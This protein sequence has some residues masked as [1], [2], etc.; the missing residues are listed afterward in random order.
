[1]SKHIIICSDGTW[2]SPDQTDEGVISPTNVFKLA[3]AVAPE[4]AD[5]RRQLRYY[6][7]GVGTH[8]YDRIRG[9]LSGWGISR[10]I[11]EGYRFL[12]ANYEEGDEIFLFGFS[13]GAYTV[14]SLAGLLRNSGLL[15]TRNRY[16]LDDAYRLYRRRDPESHP[17]SMESE[18]FRRTYSRE[19]RVHFIGVW[20][21]V[22]ALGIPSTNFDIFNKILNIEFHDVDLSSRI[23]NAFQ[24]LAIDERRRAFEPSIWRKQDGVCCQRLEQ[25]WFSGVHSNVG[26]GYRDTGLSDIALRWMMDRAGECGLEFDLAAL[27]RLGFKIRPRWD[28][29]LVNSKKGLYQLM[30][31]Y[32]RPIE[33]TPDTNTAVA[34][35][36]WQRFESDPAYRKSCKGL[37]ILRPR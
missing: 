29:R 28:G 26:G 30:P 15:H 19:V 14:R 16:M 23:N 31:D 1:M 34:P 20:D 9:G 3:L 25:V 27:K 5:G 4:A 33:L 35:E 11:L 7:E 8:W 17:R 10:N 22:G 6:D 18:I 21:T 36:A 2:N 12:M 37:A 32:I 13:R 24:A